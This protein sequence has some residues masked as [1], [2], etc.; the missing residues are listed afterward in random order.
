MKAVPSGCCVV[1]EMSDARGLSTTRL[2]T[3]EI[4][5]VC[6]IHELMHKRS[7]KTAGTRAELRAMFRDR[8]RSYD[9]R[10]LQIDELGAQ[11]S[12]A[13]SDEKRASNDR[14]R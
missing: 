7:S 2:S 9:R 12:E 4:V 5:I 10:S 11:L 1:C 14:R 3:G 13:F 8:R 6:G